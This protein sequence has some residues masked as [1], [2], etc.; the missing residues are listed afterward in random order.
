MCQHPWLILKLL[1]SRILTSIGT[2]LLLF[3]ENKVGATVIDILFNS[4]QALL[5]SSPHLQSFPD[6]FNA[7][8]NDMQFSTNL[9]MITHSTFGYLTHWDYVNF[10]TTLIFSG[11]ASISLSDVM[12]QRNFL[13]FTP[14][15]DL[16][17]FNF[18]LYFTS[19]ENVSSKPVI[20]EV[21]CLVFTTMSSTY[22]SMFL[23]I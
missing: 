4:L 7:L 11:F 16:V 2:T 12:F 1:R 20:C 6:D 22:A 19:T 14:N 23:S 15:I 3:L 17:R 8:K 5:H 9:E 10:I 13:Y 21:P 18:K